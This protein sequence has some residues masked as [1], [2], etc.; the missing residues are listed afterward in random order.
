LEGKPF[1]LRIPSANVQ[2]YELLIKEAEALNPEAP[3]NDTILPK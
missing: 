3:V 1:Y 2:N